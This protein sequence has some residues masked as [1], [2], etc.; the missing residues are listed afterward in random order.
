MFLEVKTQGA[1]QDLSKFQLGGNVLEPNPRTGVFWRIWSKNS[2][3]LAC[4]CITDSLSHTTCV[5][6]KSNQSIK[7]TNLY[8]V[9]VWYVGYWPLFG[10]Y[11][12]WYVVNPA[13]VCEVAKAWTSSL[14]DVNVR[15]LR[16]TQIFKTAL[17]SSL[18]HS[19]QSNF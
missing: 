4:W 3:S 8:K 15:Y 6:T 7:Y 14:V 11:E 12:Q 17:P 16:G 19:C 9:F 5:E 10:R 13:E 2:G 1:K 18:S